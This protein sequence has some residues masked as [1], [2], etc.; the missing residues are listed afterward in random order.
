MEIN[1]FNRRVNMDKNTKFKR[2]FV[3]LCK[4]HEHRI[5]AFGIRIYVFLKRKQ[6]PDTSN[7]FCNV[8]KNDFND[9][10]LFLSMS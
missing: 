10:S 5:C 9:T 3:Y 4:V 7:I 1:S 2:V 8:T 6:L